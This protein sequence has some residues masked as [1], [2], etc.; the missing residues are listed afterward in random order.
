MGS[1]GQGG[2][3]S[4]GRG[5]REA[6]VQG[7]GGTGG[8]AMVWLGGGHLLLTDYSPVGFFKDNGVNLIFFDSQA[9]HPFSKFKLL[10]CF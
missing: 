5:F 6:G 8:Q 1:G 3:G 7:G 2:V 9:H 4:G 10:R